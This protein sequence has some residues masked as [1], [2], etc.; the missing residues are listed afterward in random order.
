MRVGNSSKGTNEGPRASRN[1]SNEPRS[2]GETEKK[3]QAT[4]RE[5]VVSVQTENE[6]SGS[7][8]GKDSLGGRE[9]LENLEKRR[10]DAKSGMCAAS[11]Q[12]GWDNLGSENAVKGIWN[13]WKECPTAFGAEMLDFPDMALKMLNVGTPRDMELLCGVAW[14]VWH[15]RNLRVFESVSQGAEQVWNLAVSMLEDFKEATK[16]RESQ[17]H[18]AAAEEMDINNNNNNNNNNHSTVQEGLVPITNFFDF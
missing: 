9:N 7:L 6:R 12:N 11:N 13:Q 5:L 1:S 4:V 15:N 8:G 2:G 14:A 3:L 17:K 18:K 10:H 16:F